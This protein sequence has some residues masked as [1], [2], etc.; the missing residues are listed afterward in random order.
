MRLFRYYYL[1]SFL[2]L[3]PFSDL[4]LIKMYYMYPYTVYYI[5]YLPNVIE[6]KECLLWNSVWWMWYNKTSFTL[7]GSVFV[8]TT[9]R[10]VSEQLWWTLFVTSHHNDIGMCV[11]NNICCSKIKLFYT[12]PQIFPKKLSL[13]SGGELPMRYLYRC[14][15]H[16]VESFN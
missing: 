9:L 8:I 4:R 11:W 1:W 10:R 13:C 3:F 5:T 7:L 14:T 6:G 12:I 2:L 16:F 15:V